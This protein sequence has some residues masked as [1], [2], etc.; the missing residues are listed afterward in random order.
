MRTAYQYKLRPT[1]K[2]ALEIDRWLAMLCAQYNYLLA[3][4]F[5][6]Y[7]RNRSSINACPIVCHIPELRDNPDY[8][9]QKKT[10]P[11]LKKTHPWYGE[12]YS[13]VLQDIVKRVKVTFDRFLKGDSNGKRSGKPRF[14]PRDRYRTFTYPQMK[15]GCLQGNLITLPMFGIVKVILH[16]PIPDGFKIKTASVTKK[17][18][19]YY[20]TLSLEDPTVPNIKPDFNADLITGIDLGLKEFLTT[21]NGDVVPIPQ[22]YRKSQKRLRV[23]QKRVSRRKKGSNRRQKSIKQVAK[24]H[25]KVADKRKDFHFKTANNLLKKYDVIVHEDL[26]VK[27]LSSSMLAKSVHDAGWSS[28]LS[29][30]TTKAENAGLLVIA[31]NPSGTSQ[32]CSN[33]GVKVPKK[34]HERWHDCPNCG[35]SLDRDHNAALNIK[36]R[37]VGHSVLKAKSLLSNSRIVLEAYTSASQ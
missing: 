23:I 37:A 5:D 24:Q 28:F 10:L 2:Q 7:E 21:S 11:Q 25:K 31:V 14:K 9:S 17:A 13:Q 33:C 12:I 36:N 16:R 18:D 4:R 26:N 27:A 20:L 34:L 35:C 19:G 3:D 6:W 8:Y 15:D 32:Y 30:L 29:I 1:A 22:H